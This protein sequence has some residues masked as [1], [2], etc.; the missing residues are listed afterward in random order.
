MGKITFEC[1]TVTP[2]FM[3]GADGKTPELRPASIKGLMRFWW[4]AVNGDSDIEKLKKAEGEIFG[5]TEKK[6]SVIIRLSNKKEIEKSYSDLI[7]EISNYKGI[8]YNFYPIFMEKE[9]DKKNYFK[10]I[11]FDLIVFSNDKKALEEAVNSII[12]L[13]FFG[14]LGSRSRRGA[15]AIKIKVKENKDNLF[16][17]KLGLLDTNHIKNREEFKKHIVKIK[18]TINITSTNLYTSFFKSIYILNPQKDW[19]TALNII[20]QPFSQFRKDNEA[21]ILETPN[22]GFPIR[23]KG[24]TFIG[25]K[26]NKDKLKESLDRRASS[27]MFK[28]IKLDDNIFLPIIIWMDGDFLPNGFDILKKVKKGNYECKKPNEKIIEE[29]FKEFNSKDYIKVENNG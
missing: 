3:Y 8:K 18:N 13:N 12:M 1:E 15:G 25:G 21:K 17:E 9:K 23:H 29:F 14:A 19:K 10:S 2:M 7:N 4:R 6:S 5:S 24:S 28:V 22:F 11:T 20:A 27:L 16:Q 26:V